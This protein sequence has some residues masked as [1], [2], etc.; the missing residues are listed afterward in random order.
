MI[1][2]DYDVEAGTW[3]HEGFEAASIRELLLLLPKGTT[4]QD[5]YC[6]GETRPKPVWPEGQTDRLRLPV[7]YLTSPTR[8]LKK[9]RKV[10]GAPPILRRANR[11]EWGSEDEEKAKKL[12]MNGRSIEC[13]ALEIGRSPTAVASKLE[14]LRNG[15]KR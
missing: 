13:I 5:Y 11:R 12:F 2:P 6:D 4:C 14:R 10:P 15:R 7:M 3:M 8:Q 9:P 1:H